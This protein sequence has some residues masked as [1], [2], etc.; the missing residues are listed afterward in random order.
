MTTLFEIEN[1]NR[2]LQV[3]EELVEKAFERAL[4]RLQEYTLT[5]DYREC[6]IKLIAEASRHVNSE[7]IIV[8]LNE[9]DHQ[10]LTEKDLL[11]ISERIGVKLVRSEKTIDSIGGVIIKSF[12]G[13][14]TVDNT[15]ENRLKT[16]RNTLRSRI[17]KILFKEGS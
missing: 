13:K 16:L 3:K 5:E 8:E 17:A 14:V 6:L 12:D 4:K 15:F 11:E 9:K 2:L 7:K 1:K 10:R